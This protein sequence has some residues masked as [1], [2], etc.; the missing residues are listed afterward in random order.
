MKEHK[1]RVAA[2]FGAAADRYD[3]ASEL[4]RQAAQRLAAR[5]RALPL[6]ARPRVLEIGCGTGHLTRELLPHIG[7]NWVISDMALPMVRTCRQHCAAMAQCVAMDGE[8]PAF[9]PG[10]F[11]L[12]V[13]SLTAQWFVDLRA[14][15][16]AL[17]GLLAPGG[18]IALATL[19]ADTFAEWRQAH[20]A[21]GLDA[22]TP[23]YPAAT[24]LMGAFPATLRTDVATERIAVPCGDP[25]EFVRG[26]RAIG[27]DTPRPGARPL[28]AGQLRKVLRTLTANDS[29]QMTYEL[30]YAIAERSA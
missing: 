7:G 18:R 25:L 15:F 26:L 4:Q 5:V 8:R 22:A 9:R 2:R 14:T 1:Q 13:S 10:S 6:S 17:A 28:S 27:A 20:R 16:A 3:S 24:V 30:L 11:D 23:D 12:I 19:G 21:L 29:P